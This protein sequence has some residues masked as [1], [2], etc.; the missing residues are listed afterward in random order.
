[1]NEIQIQQIF[2]ALC[3]DSKALKIN[4]L[5]YKNFLKINDLAISVMRE[6]KSYF[7]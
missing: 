1:M 7:K 6:K 2:G 5:Q 3:K 4:K